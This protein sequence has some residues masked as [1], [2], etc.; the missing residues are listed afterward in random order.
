MSI[1]S[2]SR[3]CIPPPAIEFN[4]LFMREQVSKINALPRRGRPAELRSLGVPLNRFGLKGFMPSPP[5]ATRVPGW[6]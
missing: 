2:K 4:Y 5:H 1:R 3:L 6:A